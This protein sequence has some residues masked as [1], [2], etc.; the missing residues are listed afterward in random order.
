MDLDSV[1]ASLDCVEGRPTIVANKSI[2][3]RLAQDLEAGRR[4]T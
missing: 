1:K 4:V 2:D 3:I